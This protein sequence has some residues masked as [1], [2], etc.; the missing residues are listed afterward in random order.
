[1]SPGN[2]DRQ[3][4]CSSYCQKRS[5]RKAEFKRSDTNLYGRRHRKSDVIVFHTKLEQNM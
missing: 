1:M 3:N 4:M 5:L 2:N